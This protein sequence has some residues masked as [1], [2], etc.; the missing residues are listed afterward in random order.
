MNKKNK[1]NETEIQARGDAAK[2]DKAAGGLNKTAS[3]P[4]RNAAQ[5]VSEG[6]EKILNH[7]GRFIDSLR[8]SGKKETLTLPPQY[9]K[10]KQKF[11]EEI[12]I[13]KNAVGYGMRTGAA[14]CLLISYPVTEEAS[15]PFGN[16]QW[17]ID[18][19]HQSM[20]ENEGLIEVVSGMTASGRPY[21][22][23]I[24]KH[25]IAAD[26][27]GY[28]RGVEY[29]FNINVRMEN[30]I[31]FINGSFME[32]GTTGIRDSICMAIYSQ[33]KNQSVEEMLKDWFQD[34][35]DPAF[36]KGFLMN[37]S[38]RSEFDVNFPSHPLS[39]ARALARFIAENN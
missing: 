11:P 27:N 33:G 35:Y 39:E 31:Q 22:Y 32:E 15:M 5:T 2:Q 34:P 3:E 8:N 7:A 25:R 23:D 36:H 24:I 6:A 29:T 30:S 9:Q 37:Q 17:V 21:I 10:L 4:K 20:G 26:N 12:G 14:S 13:P 16:P 19:L 38:E 1:K 18:A 28:P